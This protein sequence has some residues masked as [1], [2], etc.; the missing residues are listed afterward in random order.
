M[1][2]KGED[3]HC[4]EFLKNVLLNHET[5]DKLKRMKSLNDIDD[6]T[7]YWSKEEHPCMSRLQNIV[8]CPSCLIS[9]KANSNT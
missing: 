1:K 4:F 2:W 8:D 9:P 7:R 6:S 5:L 3:T